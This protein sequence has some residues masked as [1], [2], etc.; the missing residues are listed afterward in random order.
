MKF[1]KEGG[2]RMAIAID[3]K[4]IQKSVAHLKTTPKRK[5]V[6][7]LKDY[8]IG[9][10]EVKNVPFIKNEGSFT[11]PYVLSGKIMDRVYTLVLENERSAHKRK[12]IEFT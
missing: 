10:I 1:K 11:D 9:D 3:K 12:V 8:M 5:R 6:N 4:D 7:V 2:K